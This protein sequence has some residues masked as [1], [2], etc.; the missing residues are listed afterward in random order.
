MRGELVLLAPVLLLSRPS[1]QLETGADA[2]CALGRNLIET[3]Y[4]DVLDA[5]PKAGA[6]S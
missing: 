6:A 2:E 1:E 3:V 5:V 4:P